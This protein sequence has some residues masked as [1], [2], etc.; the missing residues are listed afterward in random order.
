M[1]TVHAFT[2]LPEDDEKPRRKANPAFNRLVH[3]YSAKAHLPMLERNHEQELISLVQDLD[4][5]ESKS[6]LVEH[7]MGF[8][9]GIA[10]KAAAMNGLED[11]RDD[12]YNEGIEGF[13]KSIYKFKPE[14]K[15][16]LAT[17][18]RHYVAAS[19]HRYVMDMKYLF[20]VG[21]NLP[22]K[23]AFFNLARIRKEFHEIYGRPLTT[24][25]DDLQKA[26][27]ISGIPAKSL[28]SQLEIISSANHYSLEDIQ[29]H[30]MRIQDRPEVRVA[31]KSGAECMHT[32][33]EKVADSL[34]DRDRD[35]LLAMLRD[36]EQR[37][38]IA[39]IVAKRHKIT[40][41]RVRQIYRGALVD[42]RRSLAD[43]GIRNFQDIA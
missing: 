5:V 14:H 21:T 28:K 22:A 2:A 30:D 3:A 31:N 6:A 37:A 35:I 9:V 13:I 25:F 23:A 19:C 43:A 7:H 27:L 17:L 11:H 24:D 10:N 16:R 36:P 38:K 40:V 20:R 12:L 32:H 33:I 39:P 41:E 18:S 15:A 42:I 4:C 1:L 29:I 26:E 34:S 8:I